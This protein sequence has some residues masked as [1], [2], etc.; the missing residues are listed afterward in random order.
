MYAVCIVCFVVIGLQCMLC[1]VQYA[2]YIEMF[3]FYSVCCAVFTVPCLLFCSVQCALC[4]DKNSA[5]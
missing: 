3:S 2:V 5:Y 4:C 1:C